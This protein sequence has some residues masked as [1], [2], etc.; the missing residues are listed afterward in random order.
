[1]KKKL[2]LT[3]LVAVMAFALVGC[4]EKSAQEQLEDYKSLESVN[5]FVTESYDNLGL[6]LDYNNSSNP[7]ITRVASTQAAIETLC[8]DIINENNVPEKC[9]PIHENLVGAANE[10]KSA[11]DYLGDSAIAISVG[12]I[13]GST[14][15]LENATEHIN[16]Y[17]DFLSKA[18]DEVSKL[19]ADNQ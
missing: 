12:D 5:A 7:D 1:M 4:A 6:L 8:D 11:S 14:H 19:Q 3:A 2:L 15:D 9:K 13:V 18:D 16:N 10:L 17:G